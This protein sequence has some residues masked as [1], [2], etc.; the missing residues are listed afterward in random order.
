MVHISARAVGLLAAVALALSTCGDQ[1]AAP[2]QDRV[3]TQP[4]QSLGLYPEDPGLELRMVDGQIE[5]TDDFGLRQLV[6]SEG[7]R[8]PTVLDGPEGMSYVIV[9][10]WPGYM[11]P[12]PLVVDPRTGWTVPVPA[13]AEQTPAQLTQLQG[14]PSPALTGEQAPDLQALEEGMAPVW[15]FGIVVPA[16]PEGRLELVSPAARTGFLGE[17]E[18]YVPGDVP[19]AVDLGSTGPSVRLLEDGVHWTACLLG[20]IFAGS[21]EQPVGQWRG[22][23]RP[24]PRKA[25]SSP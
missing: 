20:D 12:T 15:T 8:G 21:T 9:T 18:M 24:R 1:A 23:G 25:S 11:L 6:P 17:C 19:D 7:Q 3:D 5:V 22:P 10:D 16:G 13:L 14:D 4:V 2:A